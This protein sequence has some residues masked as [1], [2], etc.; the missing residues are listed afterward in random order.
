VEASIQTVLLVN[1]QRLKL[2]D[3]GG[4]CYT[5]TCSLTAFCCDE[6]WMQRLKL[7]VYA[8]MSVRCIDVVTCMQLERWGPPPLAHCDMKVPGLCCSSSVG[9]PH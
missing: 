1:V 8:V 5:S 3:F 6:C 4:N 9:T 2:F 7:F